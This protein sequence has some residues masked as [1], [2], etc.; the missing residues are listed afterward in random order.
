MNIPGY[1]AEASVYKSLRK[2]RVKSHSLPAFSGVLPAFGLIPPLWQ[3]QEPDEEDV[4]VTLP[5]ECD[6]TQ[7]CQY[8][9][10]NGMKTW[11]C[12]PARSSFPEKGNKIFK[13]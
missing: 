11:I 10:C 8:T 4:C 12:T 13:A 5:W 7:C 3:G 2:F 9:I 1:T 6:E